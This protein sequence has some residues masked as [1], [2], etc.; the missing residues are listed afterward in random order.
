ML[1]ERMELLQPTQPSWPQP[2]LVLVVGS[3]DGRLNEN[4]AEQQLD[5]TEGRRDVRD[6]AARAA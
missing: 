4:A 1:L 5:G 6:D 3:T 2:Y